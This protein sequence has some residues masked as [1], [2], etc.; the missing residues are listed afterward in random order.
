MKTGHLTSVRLEQGSDIVHLREVAL[1]LTSV[2]GFGTF[3]R[4]RI[5]TAVVELGRNAIEHGK[6][7]RAGFKLAENDGR[8]V[9]AVTVLDQGN[10]IPANWLDGTNPVAASDGMGLGLRGVE[11]IATGF[12][13]DTGSE[14]TR[15]QVTFRASQPCDANESPWHTAMDALEKLETSDPM[16]ALTAQNRELMSSLDERDLLMRELHHRTGNNLTLIVALIRMSKSQATQEETERVLSEL[17]TRVAA[18]SKAHELMQKSAQGGIIAARDLLQAVASNAKQAFNA[19]DLNVTI[20][21]ECNTL[22]MDGR[23]AVDIGLIV[24]EIITNAY[25]HAFRGRKEGAIRVEFTT[26]AEGAMALTVSDNGCGLSDDADRPERS[27]SL[28]WR[29]IRTLTFQNGG[30]LSVDGS[31]GLTVE[32][33]L[34]PPE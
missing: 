1:A 8:P 7:G 30:K 18:L 14:G 22:E 21:V 6:R 12:N 10:G 17:E 4:T 16:K 3:E 29:L 23:L 13:V 34:P 32:I 27:N 33:H 26:D 24:G 19:P 20:D 31:D 5:V 2:L 9:L 11:R 28:G 25:K 15:I